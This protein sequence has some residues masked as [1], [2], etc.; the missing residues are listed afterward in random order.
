MAIGKLVSNFN[1]IAAYQRPGQT[2]ATPAEPTLGRSLVFRVGSRV[3][4]EYGGENFTYSRV[5]TRPTQC[6]VI[7]TTTRVRREGGWSSRARA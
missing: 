1:I 5:P 7:C 6:R 4:G 3:Y 2:A